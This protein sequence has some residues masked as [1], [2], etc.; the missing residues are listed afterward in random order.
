MTLEEQFNLNQDLT[1][2]IIEGGVG[3][4]AYL[5]QFQILLV[6]FDFSCKSFYVGKR[7]GGLNLAGVMWC[8]DGGGLYGTWRGTSEPG[9]SLDE[10]P[11]ASASGDSFIAPNR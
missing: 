7:T 5:P 9:P 8:R 6:S 3:V 10:K 11:E 4:W 2:E 1:V